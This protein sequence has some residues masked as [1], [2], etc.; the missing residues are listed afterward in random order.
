MINE[1]ITSSPTETY[2]KANNFSTSLSVGDIVALCGDLG[3]GKT[4][5]AQVLLLVLG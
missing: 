3:C 4:L 2:N 1:F 5:F